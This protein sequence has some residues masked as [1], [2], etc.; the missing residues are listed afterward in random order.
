MQVSE[1][2]RKEVITVT[3][4]AAIRDAVHLMLEH[5]ISGVPVVDEAGR[6]VGILTEGD[7]LRRAELGTQQRIPQWRAWITAA[8]TQ[9]QNFV[10]S[11]AR[12]VGEIMTTPVTFVGPQTPLAE[13]VAL[14]ESRRIKRIPVLESGRIVGIVT[15]ADLLRALEALLPT[16]DAA[17]VADAQLRRRVLAS[18]RSQP[19]L[20]H[21]ASVDVI[22]KDG[23][24][25][26]VGLVTDPRQRDAIRVVAENTPG[27]RGVVD[28]LTW[29]ESMSGIPMDPPA[30]LSA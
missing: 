5:H 13:V 7:L 15:R 28:H 9:A 14:M 22:V 3:P 10:R 8:G 11:H 25:E 4:R 24:V 1:V 21:A 30:G 19:W 27:T 2:M 20:G 23:I 6:T 18:L 29:I 12:Q 26:L 16:A 17:P